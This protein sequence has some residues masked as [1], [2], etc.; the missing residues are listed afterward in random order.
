L[1]DELYENHKLIF[2]L[3]DMRELWVVS[4]FAHKSIAEKIL[5]ASA[6]FT[7]WPQMYEYLKPELEIKKYQWFLK[8]GLS[9]REIWKNV[10]KYLKD[11]QDTQYIILFKWSQNTIF[12]EEALACLL[13]QTEQKKLPRQSISW[14]QK[15]EM[16]FKSV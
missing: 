10:K 16:F 1:R 7:V 3:W 5:N 4:E 9:S 15:K 12:T 8:S 13:T 6:I 2:V 14:K 11:N